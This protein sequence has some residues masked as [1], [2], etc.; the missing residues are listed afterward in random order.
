M[1]GRYFNMALPDCIGIN[2]KDSKR[3]VTDCDFYL[4]KDCPGTCNY[5][6][7]LKQGISHLAKT[8]QERFLSKFPT[9]GKS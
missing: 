4:H 1:R 6:I 5:S 8:G 2:C 3:E 7:K 9:W